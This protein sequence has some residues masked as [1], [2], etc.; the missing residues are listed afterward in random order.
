LAVGHQITGSA[1]VSFVAASKAAWM[2]GFHY[3]LLVGAAII[4][5]AAVVAYIGLPDQAADIILE[6]GNFETEEIAAEV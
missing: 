2:S 5:T 1:G 6:E 3:A 4:A